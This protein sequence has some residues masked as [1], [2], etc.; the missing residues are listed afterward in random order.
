M[1][2]PLPARNKQ[3]KAMVAGKKLSAAGGC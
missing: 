3:R 2:H 1:K